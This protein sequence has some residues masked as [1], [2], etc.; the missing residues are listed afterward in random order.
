MRVVEEW[1]WVFFFSLWLFVG[2]KRSLEKD[3]VEGKSFS[4]S[5][6]ARRREIQ[7]LAEMVICLEI[8]YVNISEF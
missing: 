2:R 7:K 8:R 1:L 3:M 4:G 6:W 5:C